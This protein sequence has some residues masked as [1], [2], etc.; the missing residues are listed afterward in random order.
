MGAS[1]RGVNKSGT[2]LSVFNGFIGVFT[3]LLSSDLNSKSLNIARSF[4]SSASLSLRAER[5][6]SIGTSV[7]IVAKIFAKRILSTLVSTFSRSLPL[8]S[9]VRESISSTPPNCFISCVAVFGPTPGQPG[10]L[11]E[12][13][14]I[15]ARRSITCLAEERSYIS[16]TAFSS[17]DSYPPP[18]RRR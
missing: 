7:R 10:K 18:W 1:S 13:S 11:S 8:I 3:N 5:S 2:T 14:P 16:Q 9:A 17:S 15:R 4:S 6:R 12:E